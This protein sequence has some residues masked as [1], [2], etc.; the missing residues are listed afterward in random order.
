MGDFLVDFFPQVM[1]FLLFSSQEEIYQS[2]VGLHQTKNGQVYQY[3]TTAKVAAAYEMSTHLGAKAR[4]ET[5]CLTA[6]EDVKFFSILFKKAT[7]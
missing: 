6:G 3:K 2:R 7:S 1:S 4:Y 5:Q